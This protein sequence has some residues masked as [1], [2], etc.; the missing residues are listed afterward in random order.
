MK[1]AVEMPEPCAGKLACTVLWGGRVSNGSSL[2]D[3]LLGAK[4]NRE[5][6]VHFLNAVLGSDTDNHTYTIL[7]EQH[8]ATPI[9]DTP[10]LT[11]KDARKFEKMIQEN[12]SK[13]ISPESYEQIM[14]AGKNVRVFN[15]LS[16]YENYCVN[17]IA[18]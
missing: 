11:G 6:L 17:T 13:R 15:S 2:P 1:R 9:K 12:E 3:A 4:E 8:M 5:L 7:R 10:V 16:D 14:N 18:S